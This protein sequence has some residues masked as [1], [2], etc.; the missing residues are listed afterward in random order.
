M[1]YGGLHIYHSA[2][3]KEEGVKGWETREKQEQPDIAAGEQISDLGQI[4]LA[5]ILENHTRAL[6]RSD[7]RVFWSVA[8]FIRYGIPTLD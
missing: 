3:Y 5:Q 8:H 1:N 2:R 6:S 4:R 7:H